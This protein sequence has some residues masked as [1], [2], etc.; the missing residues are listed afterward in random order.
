MRIVR[1]CAMGMC[2]GVRNALKRVLSI[3]HPEQVTIF[4]DLV[5]NEVVLAELERRGFRRIS[6][7]E[8]EGAVPT[9]RDVLITAHGISDRDRRRLEVA[10][11]RVIDTTCP[12][13]RR[14]HVAARALS[15]RGH[16]VVMIGRPG[17]VEV[18]GVVGD[19]DRCEVVPDPGAV[20]NYRE[21][22]LGVICQSTV[23]PEHARRILARVRRL[24]PG[25][26]VRVVDTICRPTRLRQQ[27]MESLLDL[28]QAVVVIGGRHSNNTRQLVHRVEARGLPAY[29]V[30]SAADLD[31]S[32]FRGLETVGVTAGTST[33]DRTIDEVCSDMSLAS[34]SSVRAGCPGRQSR[35]WSSVAAT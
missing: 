12:L 32:W 4:G 13:V 28:V 33:L 6:E 27:A 3:E 1:A 5:H 10:G 9:T 19:L 14:I 20:R 21:E 30:Q 34:S 11:K 22:R 2:P 7:A 23:R 16:L 25:S 24:N 26:E 29:H 8:R 15:E 35:P 18:N 17:H 31:P